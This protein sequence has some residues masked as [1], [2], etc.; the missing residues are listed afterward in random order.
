MFSG[1]KQTNM[2]LHRSANLDVRHKMFFTVL[3]SPLGEVL[4]RL[5]SLINAKHAMY[6]KCQRKKHFLSRNIT[7]RVAGI[8]S[9]G[10]GSKVK[11]R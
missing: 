9:P 10:F 3:H 2:E 6:Q 11:G 5:N 4:V 7:C 8:P 1:Q